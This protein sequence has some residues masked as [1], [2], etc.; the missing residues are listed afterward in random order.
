VKNNWSASI[1]F[2]LSVFVLAFSPFSA[3]TPVVAG[4]GTGG[5]PVGCV[6]RGGARAVGADHEVFAREGGEGS[7]A[8][9]RREES[10]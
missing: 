7:T 2:Y 9:V 8:R 1:S 3:C 4:Y 5:G 10:Y 6:A